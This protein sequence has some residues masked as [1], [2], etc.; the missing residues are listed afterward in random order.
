MDTLETMLSLARNSIEQHRQPLSVIQIS[1]KALCFPDTN[2]SQLSTFKIA[3]LLSLIRTIHTTLAS[4]QTRTIRDVF[5]S[6]VELYGNQRKVEYWLSY[7]TKNLHLESR[8]C[9]QVLPAQKG[10]CYTPVDIR[11]ETSGKQTL[12]PAH[13]SSMIP[14]MA[15]GST[16]QIVNPT[17]QDLK[18]KVVVLEKE[19]V[20]N[21]IVKS[22]TPPDALIITGK[23]YPDFLSRLFLHLLQGSHCIADWRLYTDADPHGID[24]ALKYM[25]NDDNKQYC[26]RSLV[27]KGAMLTRLLKRRDVQFLQLNQ[28]DISLAIGL[29]KR[30][31]ES[32]SLPPG[33]GT[34]RVQLQRQMF[35]LKK[36][37]MN[38]MGKEEYLL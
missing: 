2:E 27:Y 33:I 5:Y 15:P 13:T 28:R 32:T 3:T 26:C 1:G 11:I 4:G 23:G 25:Q 7:I 38:S 6:N 34:L 24:I 20:Y 12:I 37:E 29:M 35:L 8:D 18:L 9:L 10:L 21:S 16:V 30:L 14:Y 17:D 19:A 36:A 22:S 31:S